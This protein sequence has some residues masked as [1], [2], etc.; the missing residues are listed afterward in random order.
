MNMQS[1]GMGQAESGNMEQAL[2]SWDRALQLVP[3]LGEVHELRAQALNELGRPWDAVQAATRATEL[4]PG[5]SDCAMTLARAQLN[6]GEVRLCVS[7]VRR[8]A[9]VLP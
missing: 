1:K 5:S 6:F 7:V 8:L 3:S 9:T 4:L 2:N